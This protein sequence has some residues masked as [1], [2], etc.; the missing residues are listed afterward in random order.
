MAWS[1]LTLGLIS[2]KMDNGMPVFTRQSFKV[3][4]SLPTDT[5]TSVVTGVRFTKL[6]LCRVTYLYFSTLEVRWEL[7]LRR[8]HLLCVSNHNSELIS[9]H[10]VKS[11]PLSKKLKT[12]FHSAIS[13]YQICLTLY[14]KK[15]LHF[16]HTSS[17]Y[18]SI[19]CIEMWLLMLFVVY[20]WLSAV[21]IPNLSSLRRV[22][23]NINQ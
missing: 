7:S 19:L 18:F 23:V 6:T 8:P 20:T 17:T 16:W 1:P 14:R 2:E 15:K 12:V 10:I 11:E 21:S 22:N 3:R 5:L 9:F 4:F 13:I